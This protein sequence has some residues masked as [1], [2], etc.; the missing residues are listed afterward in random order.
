M[1][2]ETAVIIALKDTSKLTKTV[3]IGGDAESIELTLTVQYSDLYYMPLV[4]LKHEK[5][6][7]KK[8]L[9]SSIETKP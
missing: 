8:S 6:S 2:A 5:D 9:T 7:S 3:V 1:D 4:L